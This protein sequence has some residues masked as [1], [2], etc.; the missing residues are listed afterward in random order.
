MVHD[1]ILEDM[2]S[3][4]PRL[5]SSD[6][7]EPAF[8]SI[9]DS[10]DPYVQTLMEQA[11]QR[12]LRKGQYQIISKLSALPSPS[13]PLFQYREYERLDFEHAMMNS[14]TSLANAYIIRKALIR[15]HYLSNTV[16][17]WVTKH[18]NSVLRNHFKFAYDF[19]LDYAEFLDEA[20]LEAYELLD[21][22]D[23]N[24]GK[25]EAEKEWWILKAGMSDRGQGIRLF[26]S[27]DQLREIF[28]EWEEDD[29]DEECESENADT[30]G[31]DDQ[32]QHLDGKGDGQGV[33]TSQLRHFI[34]QPYIDPPLLLPSSSN[35]KFHIRTYVLAVGSLKVYVYKEMLAL[36][37]A[38]PYCPPWEDEDEIIDLARH[39]TNTCFQEGGSTNEGSV[40]RFWDL[41]HHVPG[42]SHDWKEKI[43][44]QI[45]AVTGEVFEA[46]ARGMMVHFQTLPNA[47]ELFGVDFLV[48]KDGVP[49]LLELNA[50]PDFGQTGEELKDL[51]VGRLFEET[52]EVAV[53]PF[54]GMADSSVKGTSD[55]SLVADLEL[56][57]KA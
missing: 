21:S 55:L 54:F 24:E 41:D 15:K 35:R 19:E 29:S 31:M 45:C 49:W 26:N 50:Y 11:L 17:N 28:E 51:V 47:F 13:A 39:L 34:A 27:E 22:L 18:P 40:R 1:R 20:L 5:C 53:K 23:R 30:G 14:T 10:D 48:D 43:F 52:V 2:H 44:D 4:Q 38:K 9:V 56:G 36:F 25:P 57:R 3:N 6:N 7:D 33:V 32:D 12:R 46:A 16:A 8:Y 42:L 37:A